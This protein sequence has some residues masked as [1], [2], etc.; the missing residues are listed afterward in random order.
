MKVTGSCHYEAIAYE[1]EVDPN[2]VRVC[3]CTDCQRLTGTAFRAG[4]REPARHLCAQARDAEDLHQ[5]RR[6]RG[7]ACARLLPRMR[8]PAL[9]HL[10]RSQP[11][12]LWP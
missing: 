3:H 7:Q 2:S 1:A 5:D 4:I 6:E 12:I 10:T 11:A 9:F 8:H